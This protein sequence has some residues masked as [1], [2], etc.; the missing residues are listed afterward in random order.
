[1]DCLVLAAEASAARGAH[2]V[3]DSYLVDLLCCN[4]AVHGQLAL[5]AFVSARTLLGEGAWQEYLD[6]TLVLSLNISE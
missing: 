2:E 1:M 4:S 6:R 5:Q 3:S